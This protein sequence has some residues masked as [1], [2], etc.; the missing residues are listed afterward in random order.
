MAGV[1]PRECQGS[2]RQTRSQFHG[3]KRGTGVDEEAPPRC[4]NLPYQQKNP[5]L[6]E[7]RLRA[8]FLIINDMPRDYKKERK[9]YYGYGSVTTVTPTQKRHRKEMANRQKARRM[10]KPR[11]G[12]EVDHKD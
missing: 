3:E 6:G 1:K 11:K 9:A 4:T 7:K 8:I 5:L 2:K 10:L 12:M